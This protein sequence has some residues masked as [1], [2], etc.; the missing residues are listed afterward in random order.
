MSATFEQVDQ[1]R[2]RLAHLA[3]AC[4][5]AMHGLAAALA[6]W[7]PTGGARDDAGN[8]EAG[9]GDAELYDLVDVLLWPRVRVTYDQAR[10]AAA[11]VTMPPTY[12]QPS[13]GEQLD[14]ISRRLTAATDRW[15]A[16]GHPFD[17]PLADEREAVFADL[18][19]W[20]AATS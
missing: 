3:N 2:E 15:A 8:L 16:A 7:N 1:L 14:D 9:S 19:A 5:S 17:G 13:R 18:R 12:G 4:E 11:A 6:D 20:N 10:A